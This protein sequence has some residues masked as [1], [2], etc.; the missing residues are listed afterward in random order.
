M[1]ETLL[2]QQVELIVLDC[3]GYARGVKER[4]QEKTGRPVVL[5]RTLLARVVGEL[6]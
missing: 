1:A 4:I 6:L 3:I 5:P 2:A